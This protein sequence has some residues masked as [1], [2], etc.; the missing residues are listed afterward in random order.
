MTAR[1]LREAPVVERHW[2]PCL[3]WPGTEGDTLTV[4]PT[5]T[6][7]GR[8]RLISTLLTSM[9]GPSDSTGCVSHRRPAGG[10]CAIRP[11]GYDNPRFPFHHPA[12]EG[13]VDVLYEGPTSAR[14]VG[15]ALLLTPLRRSHTTV[16]RVQA[17]AGGPGCGVRVV[18]NRVRGALARLCGH[19]QPPRNYHTAATHHQHHR[20]GGVVNNASVYRRLQHRFQADVCTS[21]EAADGLELGAADGHLMGAPEVVVSMSEGWPALVRAGGT[22]LACPR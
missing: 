10:P 2:P 5:G 12:S 13:L 14:L 3:I 16:H 11:G 22:I 8:R 17:V 20:G 18:H 9:D 19:R 15:A 6:G 1:E 7:I 4:R 21:A